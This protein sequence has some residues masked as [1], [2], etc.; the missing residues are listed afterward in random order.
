LISR[1]TNDAFIK[2]A[3]EKIAELEQKL[4]PI[5]TSKLGLPRQQRDLAQNC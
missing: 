4:R 2:R 1:I 5:S 3:Q